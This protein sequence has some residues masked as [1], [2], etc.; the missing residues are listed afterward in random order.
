MTAGNKPPDVLAL[1]VSEAIRE[2]EKAGWEVVRV[3]AAPA[4]GSQVPQDEG[5]VARVRV[6]GER[7]VETVYVAAPKIVERTDI[8]EETE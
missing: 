3:V 8:V 4:P 2:I 6:V 1:S 7:G 5:R